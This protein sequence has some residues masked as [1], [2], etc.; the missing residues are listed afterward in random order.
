V[1]H[2]NTDNRTRR[3]IELS[4]SVGETNLYTH[5]E[6]DSTVHRNEEAF[7]NRGVNGANGL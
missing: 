1:T 4:L 7:V 6:K 5:R 3:H 2:E